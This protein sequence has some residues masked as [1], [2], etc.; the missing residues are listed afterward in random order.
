MK[1]WMQLPLALAVAG[2]L[3]CDSGDRGR[4]AND[5][6]AVGTTGTAAGD[7]EFVEAQLADGDAEVDLGRL[8]QDH[9]ASPDVREFASM[10]VRD[11]TQAADALKPIATK[12]KIHPDPS[13]HEAHHDLHERLAKL[14]GPEFDLQY[15]DAMVDAHQKAV[16]AVERRAESSDNPDVKR[17]AS[18]TLPTIK[19]HL[20]RAKQIQSKLKDNG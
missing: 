15:I 2:A 17:W 10:M 14:T 6:G 18:Q 16:D 20:E 1:K 11:H 7:R 5:S 3:A 19:Q 9:A 8:A 13:A 4:M 12:H